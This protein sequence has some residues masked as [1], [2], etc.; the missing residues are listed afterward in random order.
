MAEAQ[1]IAYRQN[2]VANPGQVGVA[3]AD[4]L[5]VGQVNTQYRQVGI[6]IGADYCRLRRTSVVQEHLNRIGAIYHVVVGKNM[7]L[8]GHD[9]PGAQ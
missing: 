2:H 1:W 5:Q 3:P 9:D 6:G 8:F 4:R 7:A